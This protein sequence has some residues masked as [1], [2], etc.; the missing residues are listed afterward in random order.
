MFRNPE[1]TSGPGTIIYISQERSRCTLTPDPT[2]LFPSS[3]STHQTLRLQRPAPF[4][5][6]GSFLLPIYHPPSPT[7]SFV[8]RSPRRAAAAP[9]PR[10]AGSQQVVPVRCFGKSGSSGREGK[11]RWGGAG[12]GCAPGSEAGRGRGGRGVLRPGVWGARARGP[13]TR[14][15]PP[16]AP[17][18]SYGQR[19]GK[20]PASW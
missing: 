1:V 19:E 15:A 12:R 9:F 14:P 17:T 4:L 18:G 5:E 11:G 2:A 16:H 6:P 20:R 13:G 3:G 10:Q 7:R 8:T